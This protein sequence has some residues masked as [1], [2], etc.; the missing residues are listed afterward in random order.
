V[1]ALHART[2]GNPFFIEEVVRQLT[3]ERQD[4]TATSLATEGSGVAEGL[5]Q[6]IG[7]RMSKLTAEARQVAQTAS[8]IGDSFGVHLL[9]KVCE[10][11]GEALIAGLEELDTAG[12]LREEEARYAFS[13]P[14]V[15]EVIYGGVSLARRQHLHCRAAEAI[16]DGSRAAT[17]AELAIAGHH[18]REGGRPDLAAELLLKAGDAAIVLSAWPEAAQHWQTALDSMDQAGYTA[19]ERA[20]VLELLGD[21]YF[22]GTFEAEHAVSLYEQAIPLYEAADDSA[23]VARAHSK[24]G[25]CLAYPATEFDAV[26]ALEHIRAAHRIVGSGQDT[27]EVGELLFALAHT[28]QHAMR[29][30]TEEILETIRRLDA[31]AEKLD[32]GFLRVAATS[33]HGHFLLME[34]HLAEG[35]TLEAKACDE[36]ETLLATGSNLWPPGWREAL[37]TSGNTVSDAPGDSSAQIAR[38]FPGF[39]RPYTINCCGLQSLDLGDPLT[40]KTKH[41]KIRDPRGRLMS[42]FLMF[43]LFLAGEVDSLRQCADPESQLLSPLTP[44]KG[45]ANLML[46]WCDGRW[47]EVAT[48]LEDFAARVRRAGSDSMSTFADRWLAR[49]Y[50][51][52]GDTARIGAALEERVA[53]AARCGAVKF[54]VNLRAEVALIDAERGRLDEAEQQLSR[55]RA[56]LAAG[57]DWLGVG[58]RVALAEAVLAAAKH[59]SEDSEGHFEVAVE[60]FR[61]MTLPWDEAEAY[62][63]WAR[64]GARFLRGRN[65]RAFVSEKIGAARLIYKRIGAGQ[66]WL[67][68][69]DAEQQRLLATSSV[70][71]EPYPDGL[72]QREVDVLKLLAA[73]RSNRELADDLVLS[74]RTVE[75]HITNIY[76]KIGARG[77]ADAT[78]Y[79]VRNSFV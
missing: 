54:E 36:A 72:T 65:R 17:D 22:I 39:L 26:A 76:A 1:R 11:P 47:D 56:V 7:D 12:V 25:R 32:N 62:E 69:L 46:S 49:L 52:N 64:A 30:N 45:Y 34:G 16:Q 24:A 75:R 38:F 33:L 70:A 27:F 6:V 78:A 19:A 41:E 35:I 28:E 44:V 58:G 3:S 67:D 51:V 48:G 66:P 61:R 2:G 42:P 4:L 13:H 71:R 37:Q 29:A 73:G 57:E 23:A 59:R 55:C 21:L 5:R 68:R 40:A 77:R 50:R 18:W 63:L 9:Q 74:L 43:D 15:R 14:L 10:L 31:I 79:A 60:T 20:R 53:T 8:I